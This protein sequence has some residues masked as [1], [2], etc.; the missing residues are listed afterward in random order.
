MNYK[1]FDIK[2]ILFDFDG[3]L[4]ECMDVK[5]QAFIELFQSY[6]EDVVKKIVQHHIENGGI[7]RYEKIRYYYKEFLKKPITEEEV[8]KIAENFSK[9]VVEKV[10]ASEWVRGA[11][12]FLEK[13]Y[14]K[15]DLF[16]VSGAPQQE[17]D[18]VVK[19][20]KMGKE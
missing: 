5:T 1:N 6:G 10:I 9:L 8:N 13:N 7:S 2:V 17:L 11:K 20:R 18:L 12:D 3:V 16:V 15:I 4:C 19:E 14:K